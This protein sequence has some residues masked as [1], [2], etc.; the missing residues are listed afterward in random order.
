MVPSPGLKL[1][2][3]SS[4]S[5]INVQVKSETVICGM[6]WINIISKLTSQDIRVEVEREYEIA[7]GTLLGAIFAILLPYL[8]TLM[9][10]AAIAAGYLYGKLV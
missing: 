1:E 7:C 3:T 2:I 8:P 5:E 4:E 10:V 6:G 9:T